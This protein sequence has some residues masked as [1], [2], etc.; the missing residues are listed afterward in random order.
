MLTDDKV[1]AGENY[2]NDD[3][4]NTRD[5]NRAGI[6]FLVLFALAVVGLWS[7]GISH[8]P[9]GIKTQEPNDMSGTGGKPQ[10][11]K[12][13]EAFDVQRPVGSL[14]LPGTVGKQQ[15]YVFQGHGN[16][17]AEDTTAPST[18]PDGTKN[19]E[20]NQSG[21]AGSGPTAPTAPSGTSTVPAAHH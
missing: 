12:A 10:G 9:G 15:H 21:K 5:Q 4:I 13:P 17:P 8:A 1:K 2:S 19:T 14:E 3:N 20:I 6:V 18:L 16:T 11:E 7:L